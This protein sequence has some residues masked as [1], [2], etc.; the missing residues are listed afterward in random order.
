LGAP[1]AVD[2][3]TA[4]VVRFPF[5]DL[6]AAKVRPAILLASVGHGDHILAQVTSQPYSDQRAVELTASS[7]DSGGLA[8]VSYARPGK[9]FTANESLITRCGGELSDD[10]IEELLS[11]V[12]GLL[13]PEP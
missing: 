6:S 9:L 4:V 1:P 12:F 2:R 7:F 5:S 10:S 13:R 11:A 8:R 3:G